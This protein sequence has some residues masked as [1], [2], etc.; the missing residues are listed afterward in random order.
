MVS[1][2]TGSEVQAI[3]KDVWDYIAGT[4]GINYTGPRINA[5]VSGVTGDAPEARTNVIVEIGYFQDAARARQ[6]GPWQRVEAGLS[7]RPYEHNLSG[8]EIYDEFAF[9]LPQGNGTLIMGTS[10]PA[11]VWEYL[12]T[13]SKGSN[14]VALIQQW[15]ASQVAGGASGN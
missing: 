9:I 4:N 7:A 10:K 14:D 15:A 12:R 11:V 6:I 8:S 1:F 3:E 2:D 5:L 13:S